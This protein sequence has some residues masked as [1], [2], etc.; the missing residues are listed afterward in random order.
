MFN[1]NQ[2]TAWQALQREEEQTPAAQQKRDCSVCTSSEEQKSNKRQAVEDLLNR[3][4]GDKRFG[5]VEKSCCVGV[6]QMTHET[7]ETGRRLFALN[8]KR[9]D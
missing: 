4:L 8:R 7:D 2:T 3:P 1:S 5:N 9:A 6:V